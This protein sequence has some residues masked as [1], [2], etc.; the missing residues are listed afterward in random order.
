MLTSLRAFKNFHLSV[1]KLKFVQNGVTDFN[2]FM[3]EKERKLLKKCCVCN[4]AH[5]QILIRE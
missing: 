3:L 1:E 2:Y 4:K 5:Q